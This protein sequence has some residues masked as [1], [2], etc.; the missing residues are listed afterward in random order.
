M[1]NFLLLLLLFL[2][3]PICAQQPQ[4]EPTKKPV[5]DYIRYQKSV[6]GKTPDALQTAVTRFTRGQNSVDLIAVVHIGDSE[7]FN[8]LKSSLPNYDA[9]L[10][11]M[12]GGPYTKEKAQLAEME[13]AEG[14]LAQVRGMQEMVKKMLG[15]KFQLD[16]LDY[17]APNFV[18]ADMTA[19]QYAQNSTGQDLSNFI[20]RAM[21]LSQT[22]ALEGMP[23]T[24]GEA[25]QLMVGLLG[26]FMG[27]DSNTLKRTLGPIL[28]EAESMIQS[29]EDDQQS[30]LISQRNQIVINI[31]GR[32]IQKKSPRKDAILYGAGHMPDLEKRLLA[33]GYQ[34]G[35]TSWINGWTIGHSVEKN[36]N[37]PN[38][39]DVMKQVGGL[40]KM[41]QE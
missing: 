17:L 9:V 28:A 25:N 33:L 5:P 27:G 12:V 21:K 35:K 14:D 15:L 30:L 38:L 26:A 11:E 32:E 16:H 39:Q 22:G 23:T 8:Q 1:K 34:K 6:D 29:M 13:T 40:M 37:A 4:A 20:A 36:E 19:E 18:H 2:S 10:Y 7:Y 3:V 31:L 41:T 24:E